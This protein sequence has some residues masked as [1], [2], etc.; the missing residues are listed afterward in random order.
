MTLQVVN[1]IIQEKWESGQAKQG[2]FGYNGDLSPAN[3][4]SAESGLLARPADWPREGGFHV[5]CGLL[6]GLR[7]SETSLGACPSKG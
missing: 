1:R 7:R 2:C 4:A 6:A 5:L 3:S